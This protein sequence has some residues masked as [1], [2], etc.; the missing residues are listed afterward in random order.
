MGGAYGIQDPVYKALGGD[1][2]AATLGKILSPV[3]ADDLVGPLASPPDSPPH[4]AP[5]QTTPQTGSLAR[6]PQQSIAKNRD[7]QEGLSQ[8]NTSSNVAP[9]QPA[10]PIGGLARPSL[11]NPSLASG[12]L[13]FNPASYNPDP[14]ASL[15]PG[16]SNPQAVPGSLNQAVPLPPQRPSLAANA[17]TAQPLAPAQGAPR[18][19]GAWDTIGNIFVPGAMRAASTTSLGEQRLA[20][21]AQERDKNAAAIADTQ[22]QTAERTQKA[23]LDLANAGK[24][25]RF[26]P[27]MAKT[28]ETGDGV[29]Q[30]NPD[31][32]KYDIKIGA[33]KDK[34]PEGE[35][36][37]G[38]SIPNLNK[39]LSD[40]YQVLHPGKSLPDQYTLSPTATQKDYDRVDKA[41][42]GVEKA[43]GTLNQQQQTNAMRAQAMAAAEAARAAGGSAALDR[44]TARMAKPYEKAN[45]SA[46]SQLD[47]IDDAANMIGGNAEAQALG[48]PKVL[49][50]LVGGQG[51]GVRITTP[52][53]NA[54]ATARGWGGNFEGTLNSISGKGKLTSTQQGQLK[55]ILND[56]KTRITQKRQIANDAL[57]KIN[58]AAGRDDVIAA[59]KEARQ[60][61]TAL[62][63]GNA[64]AAGHSSG[65]AVSLSAARQMPQFKGK[66]D[67]D[68]TAAIQHYG[69]TV[70]P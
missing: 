19:H 23:A 8:Y 42:E 15:R 51:T 32:G 36:P 12:A 45:E 68:I 47:K 57:D 38:A 22:S 63:S 5:G 40:R 55:Q 49:T 24:A 39:T 21:I 60:K 66:S 58:G 64:A 48:I 6:A 44:E 46:S 14:D 7:T 43:Q 61:L 34:T 28:V 27:N 69:H 41:L 67:A 59:D 70:I 17:Q 1:D 10:S 9:A 56:V 29:F 18:K 65:K 31:T 62:E 33:P 20:D 3:S 26:D 50:A 25:D 37:L 16:G 30:L 35:R 52:E 13:R 4:T 54:I 2:P 11:A 53:L